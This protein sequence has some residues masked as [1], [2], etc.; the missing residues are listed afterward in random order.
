[1]RQIKQAEA[2]KMRESLKTIASFKND[3]KDPKEPGQAAAILARDTLDELELFLQ[4]DAF[5]SK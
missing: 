5:P 1:M 3:G 2:E 4:K